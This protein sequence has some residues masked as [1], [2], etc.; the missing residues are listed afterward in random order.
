MQA[1]KFKRVRAV[2]LPVLK[3]SK[4]KPRY[5]YLMSA[6][7]KGKALDDKREAA[8]L[9]HAIDMET[10]EEGLIICPMI[11]QKELND[12]YPGE[13]YKD[14]G[15]EISVSRDP[16]KKYNHVS[17]SEVSVPEDFEVPGRE[18]VQAKLDASVA[19]KSSK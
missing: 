11:M 9:V 18:V 14:R 19:K 13:A 1:S 2:S 12:A 15:F 16:E 5:A 17:I 7:Y 6:M 8:T 10:G 4:A 3:L